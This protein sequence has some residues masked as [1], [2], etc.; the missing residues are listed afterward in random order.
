M[1]LFCFLRL[2]LLLP[3]PPLWYC[4]VLYSPTT[5]SSSTVAAAILGGYSSLIVVAQIRS[6]MKGKPPVVEAAAP[7]STDVAPTATGIPDV[8]SPEFATYVESD[9]FMTLLDSEEQL[10]ALCAD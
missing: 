9:A 7:V 10:A 4:T 5:P 8:N 6:A 1:D 3:P 2:S